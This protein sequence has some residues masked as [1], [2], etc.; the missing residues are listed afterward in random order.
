MNSQVEKLKLIEWIIRLNDQSILEKILHIKEQSGQEE[1]DWYNTL[2]ES[3]IE[4]IDRGLKDLKAGKVKP[5]SQVRKK[6]E[7]WVKD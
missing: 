4:S 7:K 3:E 1:T 6:Y 2:P 5:H